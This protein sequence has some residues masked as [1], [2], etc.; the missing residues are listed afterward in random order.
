MGGGPLEDEK[1]AQWKQSQTYCFHP[2][3]ICLFV[4]EQEEKEFDRGN[5]LN[6][7]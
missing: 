6:S 2:N 3:P 1:K 7:V 5:S 4:T